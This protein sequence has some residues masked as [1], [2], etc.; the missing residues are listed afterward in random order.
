MED[1]SLF[2]KEA[3]EFINDTFSILD[4]LENTAQKAVELSHEMEHQLVVVARQAQEKANGLLDKLIERAN[5]DA[6]LGSQAA[7]SQASFIKIFSLVALAAGV[8]LAGALGFLITRSLSRSLRNASNFLGTTSEQVASAAS[9]VSSSSQRLAEGAS[10]QAASLEEASSSLEEIASMAKQNADNAI[11]AKNMM[12]Q[13]NQIIEKVG[14]HMERMAKAIEDITRQSEE[15]GKIIKIID[16]V[17]FQTNLLALNAAVEAARAG[18]AG[19]GFAVV[20]DEVRNLAQRAAEAAKNTSSLI[21]ATIKAVREGRE[22]TSL[23]QEAFKENV[24]IGGKVSQLV[25]EIA[26]ASQEQAQ[27]VEQIA[28]AVAQMDKVVQSTAASTEES[29][30]ASEELQ[31]QAQAMKEIVG[32]LVALVE[33][34]N[35]NGYKPKGSG[36]IAQVEQRGDLYKNDS[37]P[38][39]ALAPKEPLFPKGNGGQRSTRKGPQELIPLDEDK[40]NFTSF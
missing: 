25:Q 16:E 12:T 3:T 19:A 4:Q 11:Q 40:E 36:L 39:A 35:G 8:L 34:K 17:A 1:S 22:L 23:T 6:A 32:E 2:R 26:A 20:A 5:R 24:E 9:Q 7:T 18:E 15:T 33:G 28:Q 14:R 10:E 13:A 21:E 38:E 27:G 31:A 29:A 37:R 30:S